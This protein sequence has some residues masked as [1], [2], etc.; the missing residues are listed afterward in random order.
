MKKTAVLII[1][2]VFAA[3][4]MTSCGNRNEVTEKEAASFMRNTY[5]KKFKVK[6]DETDSD[7]NIIYE[8]EDEDGIECSMLLKRT[9]QLFG[10]NY[11]V[12]EDYQA[13][14]VFSRPEMYEDLENGGFE[15][16]RIS[17]LFS[18]K[19]G[20]KLYIDSFEEVAPAVELAY[21]VIG[22]AEPISVE[23]Y[24]LSYD[25]SY[26]EN[27]EKDI[28]SLPATI[29]IVYAN[30]DK[31]IEQVNF[32]TDLECEERGLQ[33]IVDSAEKAYVEAVRRGD[34]EETLGD[35]IL[36]SHYAEKICSITYNG[37]PLICDMHYS[38]EWGE[39]FFWEGGGETEECKVYYRELSSLLET[40]GW[41]T[42]C[43]EY[44]VLWEKD[45]RTVS[46]S[47]SENRLSC[48]KDGEAY[49]AFGEIDVSWK[50][51][52]LTE[53]D[54]RELFGIEFEFDQVNGTGEIVYAE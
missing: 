35:E 26:P 5:D 30:G 48:A 19:S 13:Q 10:Y 32:P 28:I 33:D 46:V 40:L 36:N 51:L 27:Q 1:G 54:M 39:Y 37:E 21:S 31:T 34:I 17:D 24:E 49:T 44:S 29:F 4:L 11:Y 47:L 45:G 9:S 20:F 50:T 22:A 8:L 25:Y 41:T 52:K 7:S 18:Q 16:E 43:S 38:E 12:Y 42:Q 23:E 53:R 2:A 6:S 15:T 14:Y 3:V